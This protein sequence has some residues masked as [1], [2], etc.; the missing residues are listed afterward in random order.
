MY[1]LTYSSQLHSQ[2]S[3]LV[4][5]LQIRALRGVME[6]KDF[7]HNPMAKDRAWS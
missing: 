5:A 7:A 1:N 6:V 2:Q 4:S 3:I